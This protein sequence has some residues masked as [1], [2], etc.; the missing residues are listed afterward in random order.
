MVD[1]LDQSEVACDLRAA[2]LTLSPKQ[3]EV[4][5][6]VYYAE[7]TLEDVAITLGMSIGTV[8]THYH[9]G[10]VHLARKLEPLDE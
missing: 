5:H 10:K 8:R 4:L 2:L 9:R 3:R 7:L 1:N 6:L